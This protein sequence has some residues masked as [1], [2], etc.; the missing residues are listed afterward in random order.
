MQLTDGSR[1]QIL[2]VTESLGI[3]G[4]ES[5]LLRTL[6]RVAADGWKISVFCFSESGERAQKL[7][8]QGIEVSYPSAPTSPVS[9]LGYHRNTLLG[10]AKLHGMM[11]SLRPDIVH[12]YL[13]RPYLIGAPAAIATRVPI[14]IMSRRSLSCYQKRRRM[15]AH[16]ERLLHRTMDLVLGNSQ[17]VVDDLIAEGVPKNKLRLIYNGIDVSQPLPDREA[18]RHE[19]GIPQDSTV[20]VLVANLIHYKGHRDLIEALSQI[21]NRLPSP[22]HVLLAGRDEDSGVDIKALAEARGIASNLRFLGERTDVPRL[23]AAADFGLLTS[24][25]EGFSNVILEGMRAGLPMIVTNVGGNPEAVLHKHTGLVVP[26]RDPRAIG[27]AILRLVR[28]PK[29]RAQLGAAGRHRVVEQY[30]LDRCVQAH[31]D[32]YS[33][34]LARVQVGRP[35][36]AHGRTVLHVISGLGMGG[37]ERML[38]RVALRDAKHGL[39]RPIVVSLTDEGYFSRKLREF[40]IELY[41]LGLDNPT[42]FAVGVF[43]L[44][45]LMRRTRPDCVMTW[46]YHADFLGTVAAVVSGIS[47]DRVVWNLRCSNMELSLG[48]RYLVSMLARLSPLPFGVAANSLAGREAHE[49]MGYHP[50][51]WFSLPNGLE[52][53]EWGPGVV[54]RKEIRSELDLPQAAPVV[55]MIGRYDPQKDHA[56]FLAAAKLVVERHPQARFV[57]VGRDIDKLPR[58]S[59]LLLLGER[60]D[61]P[62]VM[63][64]LDIFVLSSSYGEGSSNVVAEAMASE[65]PCVV[66]DVGDSAAMIGDTGLVVPPR[67]P[68]ALATA[69]EALI[70]ESPATRAE[71]G[72]RARALIRQTYNFKRS[73][74]MYQQLFQSMTVSDGSRTEVGEQGTKTV[75][76]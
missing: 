9:L 22:W 65:L 45:S 30:S 40:G 46:L 57:L 62:R 14:K 41:C 58:A 66:T 72:R 37:A 61:V 39:A 71:R 76:E 48:S 69:I 21:A 63:R 27:E 42:R 13:P 4:T 31:T 73:A 43:R 18:A 64:A 75:R 36:D 49:A 11:R 16:T 3:G 6:P 10:F 5:H 19:L 12:F 20:G 26:P 70:A 17:A 32:L 51:R 68:E 56:N 25:E 28:D 29:L 24:H 33:E 15:V 35:V 38:T 74:E 23:L 34:L 53:D 59:W 54:E 7:E 44:V 50:R 8:S 67:D 55:G 2:V 47:T 52:I 60:D 1:R